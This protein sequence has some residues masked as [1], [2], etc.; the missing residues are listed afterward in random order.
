MKKMLAQSI[1]E[2]DAN[3]IQRTK[4]KEEM[5]NKDNL[6]IRRRVKIRSQK[7]DFSKRHPRVDYFW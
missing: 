4:D 3:I 1:G 7:K 5:K 2:I 6:K